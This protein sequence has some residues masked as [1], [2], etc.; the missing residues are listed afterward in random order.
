MH[1]N[2]AH[3]W[4]VNVSIMKSME[5]KYYPSIFPSFWCK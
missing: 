5:R 1:M 3:A 4:I 2:N